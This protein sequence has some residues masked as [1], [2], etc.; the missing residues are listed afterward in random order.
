MYL[1]VYVFIYKYIYICI[2]IYTLNMPTVSEFLHLLN[3]YVYFT[4]KYYA[5]QRL[6]IG[7]NKQANVT[8]SISQS[9]CLSI[10]QS[11]CLSL[12]L[13]VLCVCIYIFTGLPLLTTRYVYNMNNLFTPPSPTRTPCTHTGLPLPTTRR[14][15][16]RVTKKGVISQKSTRYSS[17]YIKWHKRRCLRNFKWASIFRRG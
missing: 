8:T 5:T 16:R 3:V 2:Y 7:F 12:S 10:S 9:F 1:Y 14:V 6:S 11:L 13:F 17:F 15:Q 4:F